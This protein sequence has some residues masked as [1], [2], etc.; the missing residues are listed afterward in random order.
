MTRDETWN[1]EDPSPPKDGGSLA[2]SMSYR[3]PDNSPATFRGDGLAAASLP[4]EESQRRCEHWARS[5]DGGAPPLVHQPL[6]AIHVY[7]QPV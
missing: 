3:A 7:S 4:R 6:N 2:L 5:Q 1:S